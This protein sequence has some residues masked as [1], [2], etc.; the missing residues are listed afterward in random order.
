MK[1]LD[2]FSTGKSRML[3][4]ALGMFS[5]SAF[6]QFA[7]ST[8]L[9]VVAD[10]SAPNAAEQ[11]IETRLMEMGFDVTVAGQNEVSD[12][13]AEDM[14][15]VLISATVS[16]GTVS[17]NLSGLKDL[18]VPVM[19]WEPALFDDQG[20]QAAGTGEFSS[21]TILIVDDAHPLAGGLAAG[22]I[23]IANADKGISYGLP[24][25]EPVIIAVNPADSTQA[26]HFGYEKGAQMAADPAPA[27]RIGTFLLNDVADDMTEDGWDLF[28]SAVE[29][30]MGSA[31]PEAVP[32]SR[33]GNPARFTLAGNYPNPF[34]PSTRISFSIRSTEKVRLSVWNALGEEIA[35]LIDEVR[36]AGDYTAEFSAPAAASGVLFCRLETGSGAVTKKMTMLK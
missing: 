36:P 35:V 10:A 25:G 16:S 7:D 3:A 4:A 12:E 18:P 14:S 31:T 20:F 8:A 13:L 27:R 32:A 26:V 24:E 29:W 30:L 23:L 6:G 33:S 28:D 34:N 22:E 21:A 19:N 2:R 17:T 15:I 1:A 5:L 9:F 11:N